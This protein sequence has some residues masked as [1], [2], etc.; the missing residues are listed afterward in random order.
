MKFARF[1]RQ[2][3]EYLMKR[4]VVALL[5][6]GAP[7]LAAAQSTTGTINLT[8]S[9]APKCAVA[10]VQDSSTFSGSIGLGELSGQNG[11]LSSTLTGST[12]TGASQSFQVMCNSATPTVKLSASPLTGDAAGA[13]PSGYSKVINYTA[14]VDVVQSSGSFPQLTQ[15]SNNAQASRAL[16]APLAN[17]ANNVTVGANSFNTTSGAILMSGNY[18]GTITVEITPTVTPPA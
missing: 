13:A 4:L 17:A 18:A 10:N 7:S 12:V 14:T 5:L 2:P 16:T 11:Q 8:G 9:V 3:K 6:A 1:N 15:V